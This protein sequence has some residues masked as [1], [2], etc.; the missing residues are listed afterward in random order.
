MDINS[1]G[2]YICAN[3]ESDISFLKRADR[4]RGGFISTYT[5]KIN[6][7]ATFPLNETSNHKCITIRLEVQSFI[8]H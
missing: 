1:S 3:Q 8:I 2:S 5:K 7:N 6:I 4:E